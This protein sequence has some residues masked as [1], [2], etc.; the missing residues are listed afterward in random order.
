[1]EITQ[2]IAEISKA[3]NWVTKSNRSQD[4]LILCGAI[5]KAKITALNF[6]Y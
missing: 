2:G 3:G 4:D 6:I 1:M 5:L